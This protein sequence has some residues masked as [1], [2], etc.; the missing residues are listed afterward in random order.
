MQLLLVLVVL[1]QV[2]E[3]SVVGGALLARY[4]IPAVPLVVLMAVNVLR[5]YAPRWKWWIAGCAATFVAA[6]LFNPPWFISPEDNLTWAE[7]V[8]M[9]QEAARY[10][11]TH[12]AEDRILTAWPASDELNRPFLG[13]VA[14]P[15]S[16]VRLENFTAGE[17]LR[18][19]QQ[20]ESFDMVVAFSTKYAPPR[21]IFQRIPGWT[22]LQTR[23]FDFHQDLPPVAIAR[24]LHGR[25]VWQ[26]ASPGEWIAVIEIDKARLA[27][28]GF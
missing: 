2:A 16:V 20:P 11:E 17:I 21:G 19:Q 8:R 3:F 28:S 26:D 5:R 25:I 15:L 14:R 18:A 13:Y 22:R 12:Y 24:L 10:V 23:Y 9:H 4:M 7:F 6:L 27:S 1:A